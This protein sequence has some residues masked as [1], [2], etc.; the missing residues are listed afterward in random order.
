[1][2]SD[3]YKKAMHAIAR[4]PRASRMRLRGTPVHR[5]V[6]A[7]ALAFLAF[8]SA[9]ARQAGSQHAGQ[10]LPATEEAPPFQQVQNV[11]SSTRTLAIPQDSKPSTSLP[12]RPTQPCVLPSG[13]FVTVKL[14]RS[15]VPEKVHA[16]DTFLGSVAGPILIDGRTV[17]DSGTQVTGR[18][19]SAQ[20]SSP[21]F[22]RSTTS[23]INRGKGYVQLTLTT[24]VVD[25]KH[26]PLQ[27]ASLFARGTSPQSSSS[28]RRID[29]DV[30]SGT[31][32]VQ[33][34]RRLTFRLIAPIT[35][36]E[37]HAVATLDAPKE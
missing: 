37:P 8:G 25:G 29:T 35:V 12:F 30:Q 5:T 9:C 4:H 31:V 36:D 3:V 33:K 24:I 20:A 19:E 32:R 2:G 13:T 18:I 26:L 6:R 34:G 15:L 23:G 17:I 10:N 21:R 27:T 7:A 1:M 28:S 16:G 11:A 22:D 14:N